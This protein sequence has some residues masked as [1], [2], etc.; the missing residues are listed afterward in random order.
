M[1][2]ARVPACLNCAPVPRYT[3]RSSPPR[4]RSPPCLPHRSSSSPTSS[5][6]PGSRG[7]WGRGTPSGPR[8][9]CTTPAQT[10]GRCMCRSRSAGQDNWLVRGV[11]FILGSRTAQGTSHVCNKRWSN[12]GC[13]PPNNNLLPTLKHVR[14]PCPAGH[15]RRRRGGTDRRPRR[16]K[17]DGLQP[18]ARRHRVGRQLE[19][20]LGPRVLLAKGGWA[21]GLWL[22]PCGRGGVWGPARCRVAP[23]TPPAVSD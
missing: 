3:C 19:S 15:H 21:G 11:L 2:V 10:T 23:A 14:L 5:T 22:R 18:A 6:R 1:R 4:H 13:L 17:R 9:A 8:S 7:R 20:R 12:V 16:P